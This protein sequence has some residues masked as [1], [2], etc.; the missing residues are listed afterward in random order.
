MGMALAPFVQEVQSTLRADTTCRPKRA[1]TRDPVMCRSSLTAT[2]SLLRL[3]D[4]LKPRPQAGACAPRA[5]SER[6]GLRDLVVNDGRFAEWVGKT[7]GQIGAVPA[8]GIAAATSV[9]E[10]R[11]RE[12][13]ISRERVEI[14][15]SSSPQR[16]NVRIEDLLAG[17]QR[18]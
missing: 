3:A 12:H 8:P 16:G 10:I 18:G 13:R 5:S 6:V 9:G 2:R 14:T 11:R 7:S 15:R 4:E 1:T 17:R